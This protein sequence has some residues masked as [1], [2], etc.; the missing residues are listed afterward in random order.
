MDLLLAPFK[1][2][3]SMNPRNMLEQI[4]SLV[5]VV[6][7]AFFIWKSFIVGSYCESP[8]VVVLSGSMEPAYSRGDILFL[9]HYPGELDVGDHVVYDLRGQQI[10]IVHRLMQRLEHPKGYE[11]FLTKGDN[12]RIDDRGLYQG[13]Q[14]WLRREEIFGVI[15]GYIPYAGIFTI[16]VNDYLWFKYL[17]ISV[18]CIFVLIAKD[19]Q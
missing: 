8:I 11:L 6:G 7:S 5:L 1:E 15:H 2:I 10:P 17:V 13:G 16:W 3:F 4:V 14:Q 12:N 19:P 9:S 18:M